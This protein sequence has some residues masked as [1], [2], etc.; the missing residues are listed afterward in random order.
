MNAKAREQLRQLQIE[1]EVYA[2]KIEAI[3]IK[4]NQLLEE[5]AK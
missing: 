3:L 4:Q 1:I 5:L 2:E